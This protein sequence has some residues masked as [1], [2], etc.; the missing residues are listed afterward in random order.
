MDSWQDSPSESILRPAV[1]ESE[2]V[3]AADVSSQPRW[4]ESRATL[5]G[6]IAIVGV[7]WQK[8]PQQSASLIVAPVDEAGRYLPVH[9]LALPS[10]WTNENDGHG[11]VRDVVVADPPA[12]FVQRETWVVNVSRADGLV[13]SLSVKR[14]HEAVFVLLIVLMIVA[15]EYLVSGYIGGHGSVPYYKTKRHASKTVAV[16][17]M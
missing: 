4:N 12:Y 14:L 5:F 6:A 11:R 16:T 2:G 17:T 15:D 7:C 10:A 3:I 8:K 13:N 9:V 1:Y